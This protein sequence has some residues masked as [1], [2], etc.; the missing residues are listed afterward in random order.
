[1][2]VILKD[3]MIVNFEYMYLKLLFR[4]VR[5]VEQSMKKK[6]HSIVI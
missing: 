2:I 1:M 6:I 4:H 3:F 5:K